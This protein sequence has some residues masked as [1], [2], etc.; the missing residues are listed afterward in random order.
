MSGL[1]VSKF[2]RLH[3]ELWIVGSH[4]RMTPRLMTAKILL[5][6]GRR[7]ILEAVNL[8]SMRVI[9]FFMPSEQ[10]TS[11][12]VTSP[13]SMVVKLHVGE[14]MGA[15]R[16]VVSMCHDFIL[17]AGLPRLYD[18]TLRPILVGDYSPEEA[19]PESR[20]SF[21]LLQGLIRRHDG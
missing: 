19:P 3:R 16:G 8:Q 21:R 12:I 17:P 9:V 20:G 2:H 4:R 11:I 6:A 10:C 5:L 14:K 13:C 18:D 15:P 1:S 7:R